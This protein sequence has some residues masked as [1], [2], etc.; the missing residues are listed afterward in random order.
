MSTKPDRFDEDMQNVM[1][2]I[3]WLLSNDNEA[4]DTFDVIEKH[5]KGKRFI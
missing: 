1:A 4:S 5:I 2:E 3:A